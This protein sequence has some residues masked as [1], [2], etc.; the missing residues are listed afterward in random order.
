MVAGADEGVVAIADLVREVGVLQ[1]GAAEGGEVEAFG[2]HL[3]QAVGAAHAAQVGERQAR[4]LA[5]LTGQVE[6]VQLA[7]GHARE[8]GAAEQFHRGA[9]QRVLLQAHHGR[10]R[11]GA[12]EQEH[13][14]AQH[15]AAA[16]H[17]GVEAGA[18]KQLR[19]LA[20]FVDGQAAVE[21][22]A[23]VELGEDRHLAAEFG[24]HGGE[25]FQGEA[26]AVLQRTTVGVAA[27]VGGRRDEL[28]EQVAVAHVDFHRVEAGAAYQGGGAGVFGDGA[29]DVA[30][31]HRAAERHP[32]KHPV[33]VDAGMR[34]LGPWLGG[35]LG[36]AEAAAVR[37]L[38]GQRAALGMHGGGEALQLREDALV[39]PHLVGEGQAVRRHPAVGHGGQADAATGHT[40]VVG[41][42]VVAGHPG[43][44]HALEGGGLDHPVAQ[45]QAGQLHR[46]EQPVEF[47]A[48]RAGSLRKGMNSAT[49]SSKP[50][51]AL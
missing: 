19:G 21:A 46:G 10:Q 8:G 28:A 7:V 12:A 11:A 43:R 48:H 23:E 2:D 31:R 18:F 42:Q 40:R 41:D 35:R 44:A 4:G 24:A 15:R 50:D 26:H 29:G 45:G 39:H 25:H 49:S 1:Q 22:V 5:H 3:A 32:G 13:R 34:A 16:H 51:T 27:P 47:G 33:L 20:G 14:R 17:Q 30:H 38:R 6:E 36:A 37:Q 9:L